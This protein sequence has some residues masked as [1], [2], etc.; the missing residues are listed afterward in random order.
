MDQKRGR[1]P[2]SIS[3]L[4]TVAVVMLL[5]L[6]SIS[7]RATTI[8]YDLTSL[9]GNIWQYNYT[10]T[11]DSMSEPITEFWIR[12]DYGLY[13]V[14]QIESAVTGWAQQSSDPL[15]SGTG[16]QDG[17]YFA[18]ASGPGIADGDSVG[19]FSVSFVYY[20]IGD[21]ATPGEQ[22][23]DVYTNQVYV[24]SGWTIASVSPVPEPAV[25]ILLCSGIL[26]SLFFQRIF[27]R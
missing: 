22:W 7:A 6:T 27:R 19:G 1:S 25:F 3:V 10:V 2:T 20:G 5:L 11:N 24:D 21:F 8:S 13:D 16:P 26:S 14:L 9:G 18:I 17:Y 12:Y 4:S 15:F 23:F